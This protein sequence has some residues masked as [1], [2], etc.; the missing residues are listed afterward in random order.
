MIILVGC[1]Y[2][3]QVSRAVG[4]DDTKGPYKLL[5]TSYGNYKIQPGT[6]SGRD[7][8]KKDYHAI[9][10]H[11]RKG[12]WIVG[13]VENKGSDKGFF[14]TDDDDDCP[15]QPAYTWKYYVSAIDSWINAD[16]SMSIWS[17][18]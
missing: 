17:A 5:R 14:Y 4:T 15:H 2:Q 16:K 10:Y 12:Q 9:W 6:I 13:D 7:W 1:P 8:Y 18:S 3:V 11:G